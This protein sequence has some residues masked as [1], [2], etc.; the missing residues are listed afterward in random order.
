MEHVTEVHFTAEGMNF[1]GYVHFAKQFGAQGKGP[2]ELLSKKP[3]M[4]GA[5]TKLSAA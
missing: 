2:G 5:S 1:A 4:A 3:T